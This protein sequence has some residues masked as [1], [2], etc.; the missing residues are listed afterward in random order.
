[1]SGLFPKAMRESRCIMSVLCIF[2][3]FG[4]AT[5]LASFELEFCILSASLIMPLKGNRHMSTFIKNLDF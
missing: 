5:K 1:M 3:S 4:K 2:C